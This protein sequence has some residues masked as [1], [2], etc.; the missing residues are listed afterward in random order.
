MKISFT[1]RIHLRIENFAQLTDWLTTYNRLSKSSY[2]QNFKCNWLFLPIY[3]YIFSSGIGFSTMIVTKPQEL[4]FHVD[5]IFLLYEIYGGK[6][7]TY[8]NVFNLSTFG[9]LP[10]ILVK[11]FLFISIFFLRH[12]NANLNSFM[13]LFALTILSNIIDRIVPFYLPLQ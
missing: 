9:L 10:R 8:I 1:V 6:Q 7:E 2:R 12:L 3:I 5:R 13:E 11:C 4:Y